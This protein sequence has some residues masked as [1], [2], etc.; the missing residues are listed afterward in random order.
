[1]PD[2]TGD[3]TTYTEIAE[4]LGLLP[5]LTREARRSSTATAILRWLTTPPEAGGEAATQK[6]KDSDD[7]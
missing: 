2:P 7:E 6:I 3:L 5:V 4:V 1:M